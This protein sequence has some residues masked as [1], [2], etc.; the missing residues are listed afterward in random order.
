[1]P[2]EHVVPVVQEVDRIRERVVEVKVEMPGRVE[3]KDVVVEK[4]FVQK[5]VK[6]VNNEIPY[7]NDRIVEVERVK[8]KIIPIEKVVR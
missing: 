2:V 5:D 1:M 8:E 6:V 3:T 7:Y 4:L